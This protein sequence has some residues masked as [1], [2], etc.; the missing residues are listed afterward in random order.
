MKIKSG[1]NEVKGS[2]E[3]E[4]R[5]MSKQSGSFLN[6]LRVLQQVIIIARLISAEAWKV[7]FLT[8]AIG[9]PR[10]HMNRRRILTGIRTPNRE[11]SQWRTRAFVNFQNI[12]NNN[13]YTSRRLYSCSAGI[14]VAIACYTFENLHCGDQ[15]LVLNISDSL[16]SYITSLLLLM[17]WLT[18]KWM[19]LMDQIIMIA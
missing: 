12:S 8:F 11:K 19:A 9:N 1:V 17:S 10:D 13:L 2:R 7:T 16:I 4:D 5:T 6:T 15:S 14:F 3:R 18:A